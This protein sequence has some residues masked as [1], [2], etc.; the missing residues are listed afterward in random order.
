MKALGAQ[1][2]KASSLLVWIATRTVVV[3]AAAGSVGIIAVQLAKAAGARVVG[4]AGSEERCRRVQELTGIDAVVS[5]RSPAFLDEMMAATNG[6]KAH[7]YFDSVGGAVAEKVWRV[8]LPR[9]RI[10]QC[11]SLADYAHGSGHGLDPLGVVVKRLRIEGFMAYDYKD[12]MLSME[13]HLWALHQRG[14]LHAPFR[15]FAGLE[16]LPRALEAA[17]AGDVFGKTLIDLG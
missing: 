11:G 2:T 14:A 6:G 9:A 8:L 10:A 16:S 1:A 3:S 13:E 17:M 5:R 4:I 15:A 12:E 7:V